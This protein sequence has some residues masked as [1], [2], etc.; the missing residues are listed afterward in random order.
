MTDKKLTTADFAVPAGMLEAVMETPS[1]GYGESTENFIRRVI[2]AVL[3]YQAENPV[4]P[5][6]KEALEMYHL[7]KGSS[8]MMRVVEAC[9]SWQRRAYLKPVSELPAEVKALID[10]AVNVGFSPAMAEKWAVR[11]MELGKAGA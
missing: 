4:V 6:E 11:L 1:Q 3:L 9:T 5:S 7:P 8:Y 2:T 10:E